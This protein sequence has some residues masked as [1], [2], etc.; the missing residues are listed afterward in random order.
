MDFRTATRIAEL[1]EANQPDLKV[2]GIKQVRRDGKRP[3][4]AIDVVNLG[5][6]KM[7]SL[8]EKDYWPARLREIKPDF[9]EKQTAVTRRRRTAA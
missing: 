4:W 6:G 2:A 9:D 7:A 3:T 8:D 5:N 1:L